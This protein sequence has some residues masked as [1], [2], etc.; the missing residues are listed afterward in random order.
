MLTFY[1]LIARQLYITRLRALQDRD[2]SGR[3]DKEPR[4]ITIMC[5]ALAITFM[6]CWVPFHGVHIAKFVGI[7]NRQVRIK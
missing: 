6:V 1:G 2:S 4:R 3:S 5:A 7:S